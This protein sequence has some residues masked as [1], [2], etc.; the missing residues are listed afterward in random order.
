VRGDSSAPLLASG[1]RLREFPM[2]SVVARRR[3]FI[4][5]EAAVLHALDSSLGL[6]RPSR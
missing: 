2:D 5:A 4:G 3:T 1:G 6:V